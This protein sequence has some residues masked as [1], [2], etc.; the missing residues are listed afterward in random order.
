[1]TEQ[2]RQININRTGGRSV[3]NSVASP[4]VTINA[5]NRFIVIDTT[6]A[7]GTATLPLA[8]VAGA[9]AEITVVAS[10]AATFA[11]TL[12]AASGNTLVAP[13]GATNPAVTNNAS[14]TVRS[15]GG[16]NWYIVST[17]V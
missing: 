10:A 5:D 6:L 11:L 8:S 7:A 15:D 9:G 16:D 3:A 4:N 2:Y 1:M 12:A 17:I 13:A 14:F